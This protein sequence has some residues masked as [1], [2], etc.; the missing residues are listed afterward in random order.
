MTLA[1]ELAIGAAIDVRQYGLINYESL[2]ADLLCVVARPSHPA[3]RVS[4]LRLSILAR[5]PW[6]LPPSTSLV[7]RAIEQEFAEAGLE[8]PAGIIESTS[9]FTTVQL[10]LQSESVAVVP[11]SM[12]RE[13]VQAEMLTQLPL[14]L[15]TQPAGF[16]ILTRRG[17]PLT[18][19]AA[20]LIDILRRL[21]TTR[22]QASRPVQVGPREQI[23]PESRRCA[24]AH[25]PG[26]SSALPV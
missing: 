7:R 16:G 25:L 21:A 4:E 24:N 22:D 12:V 19:T 5:Y 3:T 9:Y 20:A 18:A 10:V 8:P 23:A 11:K 2:G 14:P 17:E 15:N 1:L 26:S 6:V 13:H